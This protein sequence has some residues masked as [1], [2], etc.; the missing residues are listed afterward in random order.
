M[1]PL[2]LRGPLSQEGANPL[3]E[4][5]MLVKRSRRE[6]KRGGGVDQGTGCRESLTSVT[7]AAHTPPRQPPASVPVAGT[8]LWNTCL[9]APPRLLRA[10][11]G[12][13]LPCPL[14]FGPCACLVPTHSFTLLIQS[15]TVTLLGNKVQK[16]KKKKS[17]SFESS[18]RKPT[19]T[20]WP[21]PPP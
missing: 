12:C 9:G 1:L 10:Q 3:T 17:L 14:T 18:L 6:E 7:E 19:V 11:A 5:W 21:G 20:T 16:L 2:A 8:G 13:G 15:I 4:K